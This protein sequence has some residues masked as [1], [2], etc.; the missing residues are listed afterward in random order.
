MSKGQTSHDCNACDK[1]F[2][3]ST[4][5]ENHMNAKHTEK[6]CVYCDKVCNNDKDL[7]NH[8]T[9]C[10]DKLFVANSIC[11]KCNQVFTINGLKR[12]KTNCHDQNEEFECQECGELNNSENDLKK[13]QNKE[14]KMEQVK[15]RVVCKHWR[16]GHCLKGDS[17]G[18]SH[19][20][21]QNNSSLN[22]SKTST[23]VPACKNGPRCEWLSKGTCS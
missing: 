21:Q 15:S 2:K 20:G 17:C 9:E 4:N 8:L 3:T 5:L 22:T 1:K 10:V 14:H 6:T 18:Y 13:H 11:T 7:T 12:H 23:R 16:R 19:V